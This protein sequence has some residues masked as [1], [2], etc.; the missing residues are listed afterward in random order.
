MERAHHAGDIAQAGAFD[1]ACADGGVGVAFE[2][3]EHDVAAGI[4][5]LGQVEIAMAADAFGAEALF[6]QAAI[7]S[8]DLRLAVDDLLRHFRDVWR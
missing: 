6:E 8:D 7:T 2:V 5:R 1:G 4:E 3:D